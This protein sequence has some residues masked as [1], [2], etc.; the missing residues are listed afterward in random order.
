MIQLEVET[1]QPPR[2][3]TYEEWKIE[4]QQKK[5]AEQIHFNTRKAGEG[6][7]QKIYQKLIPIKKPD[8]KTNQLEDDVDESAQHVRRRKH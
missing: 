6:G 8:K 2:E 3:K 7:D 4:Q 1:E 5:E